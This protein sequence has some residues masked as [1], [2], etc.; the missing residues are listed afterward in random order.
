MGTTSVSA[1]GVLPSFD[2]SG[3]SGVTHSPV[4]LE[5]HQA[6]RGNGGGGAGDA[7]GFSL[8]DNFGAP[9]PLFDPIP[10]QLSNGLGGLSAVSMSD[11]HLGA[12]DT[13]LLCKCLETVGFCE[14]HF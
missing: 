5:H 7:A 4:K 1:P 6:P 3:S 9:P 12:L 11:M 14:M 8:D 13:F 2:T 10:R